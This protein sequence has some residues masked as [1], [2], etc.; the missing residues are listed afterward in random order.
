MLVEDRMRAAARTIKSNY[1]SYSGDKISLAN[2]AREAP[3]WNK[4]YILS[5]VQQKFSEEDKERENNIIYN[6]I[7]YYISGNKLPQLSH[8]G[9]PD[10]RRLR[11][12]VREARE[13]PGWSYSLLGHGGHD[14][15]HQHH[16][17]ASPVQ[18]FEALGPVRWI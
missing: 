13:W 5:L 11:L 16:G 1:Q 10:L 14:E 17:Q 2:L 18:S 4:K 6:N 8:R 9:V 15:G 3:A 7:T 12:S